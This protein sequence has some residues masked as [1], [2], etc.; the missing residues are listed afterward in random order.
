V[1]SRL[2]LRFVILAVLVMAWPCVAQ[3]LPAASVPSS[4]TAP[5]QSQPQLVAD[6]K[7]AYYTYDDDKVGPK[8]NFALGSLDPKSG[9]L[10]HVDLTNQGAAVDTL[11]LTDFFMNVEDKQLYQKLKDEEKYEAAV[12]ANPKKY[13][14]HYR[15]LNPVISP[16][17]SYLPLETK[18][19][20]LEGHKHP[21]V[22]NDLWKKV[23]A[24]ATTKPSSD[25]TKEDQESVSY[26]WMLFRGEN[27]PFLRLTKT[28]TIRKNDYTLYMSLKVENLSGEAISVGIDQAGPCGVTE[29]ASQRDYLAAYWGRYIS[30]DNVVGVHSK[31]VKDADSMTPG[32]PQ[33][34]GWTNKKDDANGA[35]PVLWIGLAN[36]FFGSMMYL[37]SPTPDRLAALEYKA[38]FYE[39]AAKDTGDAMTYVTGVNVQK[40]ALSAGQSKTLNFQVFAGPKKRD[41]LENRDDGGSGKEI[42]QKLKYIGIVDISRGGCSYCTWEPLIFGMMWLLVALANT[43]GFHNYGVAIILLVVLV[44]VLLH[45][46]TKKGQVSMMK[47]QK[48][49]PLANKLKEK[50]AND[51]ET[52]NR[53][54][55]NLYKTQG[56]APILGF[57][58]MILQMPI[59]IALYT[60]CSIS[61]ELRHAAFLP[62]WLTDLAAPDALIKFAAPLHVPFVGWSIYGLNLLP[63]LLAVAT[64]LQ[65]KLTPQSAPPGS[66]DAAKQQKMMMYMMPIMMLVFFYSM[67]SGLTLYIM[68]STFAGVGEQWVIRR[69]IRQK[70]AME[71]ALETTVEVPGKGSRS[72]RPRKPK[73]PNWT[74][75]S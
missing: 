44:R 6:S 4:A 18:S 60:A 35:D 46:L 69:H 36:K 52:L 9:Y 50:Y 53:E 72:S 28:Y 5:A 13:G 24:P 63:L 8:S 15:L 67:P 2:N 70:E 39:A 27:K 26:D 3:S 38:N 32:V 33:I 66:P 75:N 49:A 1:N 65:A 11:R 34:V 61:V 12:A 7:P 68:A 51:K 43:V 42:Y 62:V 64:V 71:A 20:T 29:S 19:L 47:M 74:K 59:W 21:F 57:L 54:M 16:S 40:L 14:G 37:E 31:Y 17:G 56:A 10:F 25:G 22:H 23:N 41:V 58:P 30:V 45:P 48:M 55:M 73:G